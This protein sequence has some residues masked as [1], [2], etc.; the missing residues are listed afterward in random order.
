MYHLKCAAAHTSAQTDEAIIAAYKAFAA[1]GDLERSA[2]AMQPFN[3]FCSC[4]YFSTE[5]YTQLFTPH[6]CQ[7]LVIS[8]ILVWDCALTCICLV[9]ALFE[10]ASASNQQIDAAMRCGVGRQPQTQWVWDLWL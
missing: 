10:L 6:A 5:L 3:H 7:D 4:V 1:A 9:C 2:V 8:S